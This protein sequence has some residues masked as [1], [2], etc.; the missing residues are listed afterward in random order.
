MGA[1][2]PPDVLAAGRWE[3]RRLRARDAPAVDA[4][5]TASLEHLR[6]WMPWVADEPLPPDRR[7]ALAGGWEAAFDAGEEF[8]YGAFD[9]PVLVGMLGL[10]RRLGPAGLEIGYWVHVDHLRLGI[11]TAGAAALTTAAFGLEG[12]EVVEIHHDR[13]N[14][15][16][17][18]VPARLGFTDGGEMAADRRAPAATGVHR[19]WRMAR[20]DWPGTSP[21]APWRHADA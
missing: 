10:H 3:L 15:V 7:R 5:V 17:G 20:R 18:R 19:V 4:A 13:A 6:P 9:G 11:A 1:R 12:I 2:R 16:S 21:W 8:V 14:T